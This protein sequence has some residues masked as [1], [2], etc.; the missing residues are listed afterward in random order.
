MFVWMIFLRNITIGILLF[1]AANLQAQQTVVDGHIYD[2]STDIPLMFAKVFFL[3][4]Q[5]GTTTDS[6]GYFKLK[7]ADRNIKFDTIS[8]SYLGYISQDIAIQRGVEQSVDVHL[9]TTLFADYQEVVAKAGE[10]PA[11]RYMRQLIAHKEANNPE[12]LDSYSM[13]Q[14]AKIRFDLNNFT[15]K[16]KKNILVRPFDY[17]WENTQVTEDGVTYLP[18]L[19]TERISDHY[20][21]NNPKDEKSIVQGEKTTGLQGRNLIKFTNDLYLTPNIYEDYV[22]ILGKSFP[23][24]LNDNYKQNYKF[25]LEDSLYGDDGSVTY[26]IR[27]K[28]KH[29]RNLAFTGDM[30]FDSASYAVK[31]INLRFDVMANVNFVRSY[32]ITQI[33]DEVE[34]G[35]WMLSESQVIGD[36]TVLEN[37]SDLTGFFG[38][39]KALYS[40]YSI[41]QPIDPNVF[42]GVDPEI[43]ADSATTHS[44]A[45]WEKY[46][47]EE[48]NKEEEGLYDMID[49]VENDKAFKLRK[50]I[51]YLIGTGYIPIG[52]LQLA[53][54]YSFYSY[55]EVEKSR[56]KL[57]IR[58]NPKNEFPWYFSAYGAYGTYDKR[59]KYGLSTDV[60][61]T[62]KGI[63][64]I[65]V[66]YYYDI[67]QLSRSFNQIALDHV[68][69]SLSQIGASASRNYVENFHAY[70][71]KSIVT[72]L[73]GR[74]GY[75]HKDY[76]PTGDHVYA[77]LD[78]NTI[79]ITH[80]RYRTAGIRATLKFSYL[81]YDI[82]G[83]FYDKKDLYREIRKY[84][85]VAFQYEYA[86]KNFFGSSYDYQKLKLSIRQKVDAKKL[87]YFQYNVEG[88]MT[89][90]TVPHVSLDMPFGNQLLFADDYAFNLMRFMEFAADRYVTVH[91][92]HHFDG[93]ILD[94]I[95]LVNK[96][97]WRSYIFGKAYFGS[98]SN[99]NNEQ[100]YFF[101]S[102]L[103]GIK[104][105]YY[106]VGFGL[107]NIFKIAR[108]DFVWRLT[109]GI[110]EYYW[111]LVKPSF[112]IGF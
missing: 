110:D 17:I 82:K 43:Y 108:M 2:D 111:F 46:R 14:Y 78:G 9:Y 15:D 107:E 91:L 7:I 34:P 102:E 40:N 12:N 74:I 94:L 31:E 62:K 98:I 72:G 50:N 101:P 20:F 81:Y 33:Y 11:W 47:G 16:I 44:D 105:P 103:T 23:S 4:T 97:K 36:F 99:A 56:F 29:Q 22:T 95:P 112:K 64:R 80:D 86:D 53:N 18:V 41:N 54:L 21:T 60:N 49:R 92:S 48:L 73:I 25:Y 13:E 89:I 77:E 66:D 90:G 5:T 51:I 61:L 32:Y 1:L 35:R 109:P 67:D 24:P 26:H 96:L 19:M 42:K 104:Q 30:Y 39:K 87:G 59:W 45:Y 100:R 8:I 83:S 106:E 68:V 88:G 58:T 93:L 71:E 37:S 3:G 65:G 6:T 10:N 79:P 38:R 57:G 28:P 84:P 75:F 76:S 27:F 52:A 55:N 63:T 69:S 70:F 85:D